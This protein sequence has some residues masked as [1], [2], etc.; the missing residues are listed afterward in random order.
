MGPRK[1]VVHLALIALLLRGFLPTGWMPAAHGDAPLVLCSL[2]KV[3]DRDTYND[4]GGTGDGKAV[5]GKDDPRSHEQ[6]CP[7]GASPGVAAPDNTIF[8]TPVLQD[9]DLDPDDEDTVPV[10]SRP[11]T[12]Q[13]PRAPPAI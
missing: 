5:P 11:H 6:V 1:A 9:G 2:E 13:S 3:S 8:F 12:P 10:H 4:D 7:F